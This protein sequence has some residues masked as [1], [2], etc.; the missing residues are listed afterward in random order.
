[1]IKV[2]FLNNS[3]YFDDL[4]NIVETYKEKIKIINIVQNYLK[5]Y[6]LDLNIITPTEHQKI[7]DDKSPYME[8]FKKIYDAMIANPATSVKSPDRMTVTVKG[9]IKSV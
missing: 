7:Q 8:L 6:N 2:Y 3:K 5:Q 1:M 4:K 9:C